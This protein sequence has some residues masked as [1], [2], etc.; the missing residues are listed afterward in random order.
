M[1]PPTH[2][3]VAVA[4]FEKVSKMTLSGCSRNVLAELAGP[5]RSILRNLPLPLSSKL[6][7]A[8]ANNWWEIL[9]HSNTSWAQL[10]QTPLQSWEQVPSFAFS[11]ISSRDNLLL[12]SLLL[13]YAIS[14]PELGAS[15]TTFGP[16]FR[17]NFA[18]SVFPSCFCCL[19]KPA[20]RCGF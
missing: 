5:T 12:W 17:I 14:Q 9:F 8:S 13:D 15:T 18:K 11:K 1:L 3:K 2:A 20:A 6:V 7:T 16:L 19:P 4:G 10:N